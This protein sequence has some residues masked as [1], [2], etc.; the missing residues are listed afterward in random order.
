MGCDYIFLLNNDALAD[1]RTVAKLVEA[2]AQLQ[3]ARTNVI[4]THKRME[5]VRD[6]LGIRPSAQE[7]VKTT[8]GLETEEVAEAEVVRLHG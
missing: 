3:A 5:K 6:V 2:M 1:S 4:G 7:L 8:G